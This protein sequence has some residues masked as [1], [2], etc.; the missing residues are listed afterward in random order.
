V[1]VRVEP[2]SLL[3]RLLAPRIVA[4]Y[5]R[6]TGRLIRYRGVSN[7]AGPDGD[8]QEVEIAYREIPS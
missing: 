7:L 5:D 6:A 2:A 4:E 3:L 1:R 8:V